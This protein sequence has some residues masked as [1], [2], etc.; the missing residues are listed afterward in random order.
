MHND[1]IFVLEFYSWERD[2]EV[3]ALTG[4][5][6]IGNGN[7]DWKRLTLPI[8]FG[9]GLASDSRIVYF[10][11]NRE[12]SVLSRLCRFQGWVIFVKSPDVEHN[13]LKLLLI[14]FIV[15]KKSNPVNFASIK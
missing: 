8:K 14:C 6:K 10:F 15:H 4:G 11:F 1:F 2:W 5:L 7:G 12:R 9:F 13:A 3:S